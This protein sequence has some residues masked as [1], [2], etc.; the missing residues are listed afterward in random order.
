MTAFSNGSLAA[1]TQL[2]NTGGVV[3]V[4]I[5]VIW[6]GLRG[7]VVTSDQ[8]SDCRAARDAYL[9]EWVRATTPRGPTSGELTVPTP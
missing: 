4:L 9:R 7:D 6:L 3:A 8:L 1:I 5:V 2:V